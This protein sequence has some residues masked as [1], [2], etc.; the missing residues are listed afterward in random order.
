MFTICLITIVILVAQMATLRFL[1]P[2]L[3]DGFV[4]VNRYCNA[5]YSTLACIGISFVNIAIWVAVSIGAM[6]VFNLGSAPIGW[7]LSIAVNLLNILI[8][9]SFLWV[10]GRIFPKVLYVAGFFRAFWAATILNAVI[11]LVILI[12]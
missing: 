12:L 7:F 4:H 2:T 8:M 5:M 1:V 6:L 10:F 11:G 9:A 3:T